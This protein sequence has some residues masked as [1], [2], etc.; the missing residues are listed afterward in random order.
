LRV[1]VDLAPRARPEPGI[2][3]LRADA[4][5]LPLLGGSFDAILA[6][7]VLEHIEADRAV[8]REML[9]VL[10][11]AG[12]IWL[13]TPARA[14]RFWPCFIHPYAN[15]AFGHVRNGYTPDQLR[16]LLPESSEWRMELFFWDEPLLRAAFVP[17]HLLD[18][19]APPLADRL[20]RWCFALDRLRPDGPRGHLFGSVRRAATP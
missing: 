10:A 2:E 5:Q 1:G 20:T 14:T 8:M 17:L 11:P 13:S 6:F 19:F 7:D 16:A 15:R 18:R 4:T 3:L 12:T 9:R